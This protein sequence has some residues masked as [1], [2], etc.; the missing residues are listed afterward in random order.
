MKLTII[1]FCSIMGCQLQA[2]S[3]DEKKVSEAVEN[4][5]KAM[6]DADKTVLER[7]TAAELSYGHSSGNIENKKSFVENLANSKSDFVV[8]TLTEQ[9]IKIVD[10]I[11]I[12]RHKL[13]GETL[14]QGESGIVNLGVLLVWQKQKGDWRLIAR[15][16]FK[17]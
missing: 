10:E 12:V 8:I 9:T 4:L 16:A 11:A 5:R 15:Q 1:L 2:Q 6:V 13:S 3:L 7:I 17:L 14:T